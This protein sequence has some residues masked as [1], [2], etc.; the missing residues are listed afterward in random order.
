[1]NIK[2]LKFL[3]WV[4]LISGVIKVK[5]TSCCQ[6]KPKVKIDNTSYFVLKRIMT[7]TS[8]HEKQTDIE[9]H[10]LRAQPTKFEIVSKQT[11]NEPVVI[12]TAYC[13]HWL[14]YFS[15]CVSWGNS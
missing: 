8:S 4:I 10:A 1:M 5:V 15:G 13:K 3:D 2:Q 6:P 7:D 11:I 12:V 9:N 14:R